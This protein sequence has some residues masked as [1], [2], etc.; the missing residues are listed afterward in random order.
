MVED[1][2]TLVIWR[3]KTSVSY[4]FFHTDATNVSGSVHIQNSTLVCGQ[5]SGIHTDTDESGINAAD[6]DQ[7]HSLRSRIQRTLQSLQECLLPK[8]VSCKTLRHK[9]AWH[10]HTLH[11]CCT[12]EKGANRLKTILTECTKQSLWFM[13][14]SEGVRGHWLCFCPES[15]SVCRIECRPGPYTLPPRHTHQFGVVTVHPKP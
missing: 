2:K 3:E 14:Y 11:I 7:F 12:L 8:T 10:K 15:F 9:C 13:G 1:I 4:T 5:Q 6:L